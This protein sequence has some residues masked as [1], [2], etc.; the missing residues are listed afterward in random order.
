MD[1]GTLSGD[2]TRVAVFRDDSYVGTG[3]VYEWKSSTWSLVGDGIYLGGEASLSNDGNVVAGLYGTYIKNRALEHGAG[4][5]R[6][7]R[8]TRCLSQVMVL[9]SQ[10]EIFMIILTPVL[11]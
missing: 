3:Y 7:I 2:G 11:S 9:V 1:A 10:V 5:V 4:F 8:A 6:H